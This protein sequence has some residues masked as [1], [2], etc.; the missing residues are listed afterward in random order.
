MV[1]VSWKALYRLKH[2]GD[3]LIEAKGFLA[4]W[5]RLETVILFQEG[6]NYLLAAAGRGRRSRFIMICGEVSSS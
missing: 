5:A 3:T 2:I 1:Q 4:A 6:F